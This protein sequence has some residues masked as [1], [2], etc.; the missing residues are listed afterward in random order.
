M[1]GEEGQALAAKV[2]VSPKARRG[3]AAVE[4][5]GRLPDLIQSIVLGS[6]QR[7]DDVDRM[8]SLLEPDFGPVAKRLRRIFPATMQPL[9]RLPDN[10][11]VHEK[12][13]FGLDGVVLAPEVRATLR[14]LVSEHEKAEELARYQ[15]AARHRVLLH[16]P[17]GNGKTMVA[18]ALATEL[19]LPFLSVRYGGLIESHFGATSANLE[20]VF[21][22]VNAVPCVLFFDEFDTVGLQRGTAGDVGEM[23][24]VTNQLLLCVEKLSPQCVLVAATNTHEALDPAVY[25]RFDTPV[26]IDEPTHELKLECVKRQLG[27]SVVPDRDLTAL[28]PRVAALPL[29]NLN[30]VTRLC[31]RIRRD[32]VLNEGGGV[33][34]VLEHAEAHSRGREAEETLQ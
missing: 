28:M 5:V 29:K 4:A 6:P 31:E 33:E 21:R 26:K 14:A 16:G 7:A 8:V 18:E 27:R 13:R 12:P 22:Y 9:A 24:R 25:R 17:P 19:G 34:G 23:R 3:G 20:K 10:F 30:E 2:A 32:F 11:L 15:L 1:A